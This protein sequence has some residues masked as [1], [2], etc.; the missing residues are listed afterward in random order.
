METT[1]AEQQQVETSNQ[2]QESPAGKEE[3]QDAEDDQ[4]EDC[5]DQPDATE[6]AQTNKEAKQID[7]QQQDTENE[8]IVQEIE[9][10]GD[11][12]QENGNANNQGKRV[13]SCSFL[14]ATKTVFI[15]Q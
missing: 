15:L 4:F 9:F 6:V 1:T 12:V 14:R 8:V 5:V 7:Q 13:I 10:N 3:F 11:K 2:Q